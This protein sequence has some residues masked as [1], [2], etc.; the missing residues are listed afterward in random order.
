MKHPH[1]KR[2][3]TMAVVAIVVSWMLAVISATWGVS[4]ETAKIRLRLTASEE[5]QDD[6]EARLRALEP[7]LTKLKN[8]VAWIRNHLEGTRP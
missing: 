6:H 7:T 3:I 4:G 2:R 8:D 1:R 5:T